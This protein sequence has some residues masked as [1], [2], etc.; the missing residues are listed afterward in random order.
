MAQ[1][2]LQLCNTFIAE[3]G[4]NGNTPIEDVTSVVGEAARV[5]QFIADA[6]FEI[7]QLNANWNFMWVRYQGV[8]T[9]GSD[10]I[11]LPV[12]GTDGYTMKKMDRGSLSIAYDTTT[13]ATRPIYQPWRQFETQWDSH[14]TKDSS[15]TPQNWSIR[16]D[17]VMVLSHLPLTALGVRY[18]LWKRPKRMSGSTEVSPLQTMTQIDTSGKELNRIVIVRAKVLW[19]EAEG[20]TEVMQGS[21]AEYQDLIEELRSLCLPSMEGDRASE[22]DVQLCVEGW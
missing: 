18:E 7:Q 19:A 14:G 9:I 2:Y 8:L 20:D 11:P 15:D 17:G 22:D 12:Q 1:N 4:V 10:V 13:S 6:D 3:R 21:L 5:V 16:P